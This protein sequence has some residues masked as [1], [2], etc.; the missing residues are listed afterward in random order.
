MDNNDRHEMSDHDL[1]IRIDERVEV[2]QDDVTELNGF[3][4]RVI[5]LEVIVGLITGG[6]GTLAVALKLGGVI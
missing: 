3:K 4:K 6:G 2:L 1:L 5:R